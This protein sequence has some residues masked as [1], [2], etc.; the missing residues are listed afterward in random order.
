[1]TFCWA[2]G[3]SSSKS[4]PARRSQFSAGT[5]T[6]T[7]AQP[8]HQPHSAS[9]MASPTTQTTPPPSL[10][11]TGTAEL[12]LALLA[13]PFGFLCLIPQAITI[14]MAWN[15]FKLAGSQLAPNSPKARTRSMI[16]IAVSLVAALLWIV[17]S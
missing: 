1:M 4:T 14:L 2:C 15:R 10:G 12:L 6:P 5:Q 13:A 9:Q 16:A 7:I 8:Q 3:A 11:P 17:Y